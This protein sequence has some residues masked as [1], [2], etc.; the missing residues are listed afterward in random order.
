VLPEFLFRPLRAIGTAIA[1]CGMPQQRAHSRAYLA[2]VLPR[3]PGWADAFRHFFAFEESLMLRLRVA[4]GATVPCE[5][6]PGADDFRTWMAS[7][8]PALL[9]T[10]HLGSSDLLGCQLG[11]CG[12]R[13]VYI[14]RQRVGNSHDTDA[15]ASRVGGRLRFIWVN[16]REDL[17][18][19]LKD[20]IASG[21]TLALQCDR[22]EFSARTEVFDFLGAR[23]VFP[24]TIYHLSLIFGRP[25]LLAAG[26]PA[27][28]H[29][30]RLFSSPR[31]VPQPGE[32]RAAALARARAHFQ[33]F[34]HQVEAI[35]HEQPYLWFNF[36]PLNPEAPGLP[37]R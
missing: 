2:R 24:F 27:A 7:D 30:N 36:I 18:F 13:T 33:D 17:L 10:M 14:V 6:A 25:V 37:A 23:R 32:S 12:N 31:F 5:F 29:L 9:G 11:G 3:A 20:A 21:G 35:L 26:V 1:V 22:L 28:R 8:E 15:L 19:R 16:E 34:L 4:N